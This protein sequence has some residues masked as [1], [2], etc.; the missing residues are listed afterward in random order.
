VTLATTTN[1]YCLDI[2]TIRDDLQGTLEMLHKDGKVSFIA[3]CRKSKN[4]HLTISM[5]LVTLRNRTGERGKIQVS[6]AAAEIFR[7]AGKS[8]WLSPREHPVE[9]K[10]KGSMTVFCVPDRIISTFA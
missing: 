6:E 10:G 1:T 4:A 2:L 5:V 7:V 8:S 9:A 3:M